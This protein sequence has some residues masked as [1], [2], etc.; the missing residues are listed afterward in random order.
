[1]YLSGPPLHV[2]TMNLVET[3]RRDLRRPDC[4]SRSRPAST[5][6]NFADCV[7]LGFMPITIC[8]DL[9]RPGGYARLPAYLRSSTSACAR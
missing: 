7:A 2:L 3:L 6:Q 1:M 5:A 4:R 9:L 8:T